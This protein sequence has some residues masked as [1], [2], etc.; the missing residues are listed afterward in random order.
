[1]NTYYNQEPSRVM[2]EFNTSEQGLTAE[3]VIANKEKYGEN[4]LYEKKKKSIIAIFASQF[5]DLLVIILIIAALIS[6]ATGNVE[7][8]IVIIAVLILNAI[9]GTIQYVKAEKSL[10]S[11]KKLSC[12]RRRSFEA[13]FSR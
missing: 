7:S 2:E 11:L 9:L 13:A 10:D 3:Q 12:R 5:K 4:K 8:T 6:T 1:M